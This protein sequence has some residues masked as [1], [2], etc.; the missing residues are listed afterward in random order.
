MTPLKA[1]IVD[2]QYSEV[3]VVAF[4]DTR[5]KARYLASRSEWFADDPL[6]DLRAR[7]LPQADHL[8]GAQPWLLDGMGERHAVIMRSLGWHEY[9]G[10]NDCCGQC[11]LYQWST[12]PVSEVMDG[13]DGGRWC[14]ECLAAREVHCGA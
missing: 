6:T 10:V 4:A 13:P 1:Y 14:L 12:V 5:A 2:T 11:G 8:A 7:R 9:D 3:A